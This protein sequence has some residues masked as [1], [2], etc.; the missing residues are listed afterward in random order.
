MFH[1]LHLPYHLHRYVHLRPHPNPSQIHLR[2]HLC[3]SLSVNARLDP[4]TFAQRTGRGR[5][6]ALFAHHSLFLSRVRI[7]T[8]S[9]TF[10]CLCFHQKHT[11][12]HTHLFFE[13][14]S[15]AVAH[16]I[17]FD[18]GE[19]DVEEEPIE[20]RFGDPLQGHRQQKH[21]HTDQD[22]CHERGH[23]RLLHTHYTTHTQ[24]GT[25]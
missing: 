2:G 5:S 4:L 19:S 6:A 15:H 23:P 18:G 10:I 8:T 3:S 11:R 14:Q 17:A 12:T 21:T 9:M 7:C 16:L 13:K 1:Q 20:H 22:V 25:I 24:R